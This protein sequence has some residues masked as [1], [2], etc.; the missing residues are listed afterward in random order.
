[1]YP[2]RDAEAKGRLFCAF[3][4]RLCGYASATNNANMNRIDGRIYLMLWNF[5]SRN[6]TAHSHFFRNSFAK[7]SLTTRLLNNRKSRNYYLPLI[8]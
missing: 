6:K 5:H 7:E 4:N 3:T 8:F 1:M 2:W